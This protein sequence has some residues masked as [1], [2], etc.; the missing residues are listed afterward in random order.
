MPRDSMTTALTGR[1]ALEIDRAEG[2]GSIASSADLLSV[3]KA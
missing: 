2:G 1:D 3:N